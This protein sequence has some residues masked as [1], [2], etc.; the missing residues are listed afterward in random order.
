MT[1]DSSKQEPKQKQEWEP[2]LE[3]APW[4]DRP[5]AG[6]NHYT[7]G[8]RNAITMTPLTLCPNK[9]CDLFEKAIVA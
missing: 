6:G 1:Q 8:F 7:L 9:E 3:R 4:L 2:L 5:C